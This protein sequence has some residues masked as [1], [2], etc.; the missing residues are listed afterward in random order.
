MRRLALLLHHAGTAPDL[1]YP[2]LKKL[3]DVEIVTFYI[4][5]KTNAA[6]NRVYD[7]CVGTIGPSFECSNE[8]DMYNK[9]IKYHQKSP[10]TGVLT[11]AEMLIKT[12]NMLSKLLGKSYMEDSTI[13]AL[14]NKYEQRKILKNNKVSVPNFYEILSEK[15]LRRAAEVIG[16]PAI[17]KP[18]YGGGA[19]GIFEVH[20]FETLE[21]RYQEEQEK[22]ENII[23]EG[24]KSTFNLEEV[25]IGEDWQVNEKLADYCSVET[26]VQNGK[27]FHLTVS[28][29]TKLVPPFRESGYILPSSLAMNHQDE[30]KE[31]TTRALKA[32]KVNNLMTHT[33]IKFTK[34]GPKIIEVNGRPGGTVPFR[35]KNAT[36]G[37]YDLFIELAKLA[38][39]DKINPKITYKKFSASKISHCP[40]GNWK[41]KDINFEKLK[42][43]PSLTLLIPIKSAGD[44]VDSYRGIEDILGLYYLENPN[45]NELINDM[46]SIDDLL[47]VE[48]ERV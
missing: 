24:E 33:E 9:V 5:S 41:I 30:V 13:V 19:Y 27:I 35:L 47:K 28:D 6:L 26:I 20:D 3:E 18:N 43:I 45:V 21:K 31:L 2:S 14:Q 15:D 22:F 10:I 11:F 32:L 38:L 16:F 29:R 44:Y 34:N 40:E 1:I 4:K 7:E 48:Y 12:A 37:E 42:N 36:D 23:L 8:E 25:I 39:G 17:L 46:V